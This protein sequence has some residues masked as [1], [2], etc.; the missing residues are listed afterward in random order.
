MGA[1]PSKLTLNCFSRRTEAPR[2]SSAPSASPTSTHQQP[3]K[4]TTLIASKSTLFHKMKL[5]VKGKL[6]PRNA[7][8]DPS[9]TPPPP[10]LPLPT[11]QQLAQPSADDGPV[12]SRTRHAKKNTQ[13]LP[14]SLIP[15]P[16]PPQAPIFAFPPPAGFP[17][18][19]GGPP[20]PPPGFFDQN[21]PHPLFTPEFDF[22]EPFAFSKKTAS[23]VKSK[24]TKVVANLLVRD[25]DDNLSTLRISGRS[26]V[27]SDSEE[28]VLQ[29]FVL[30]ALRE[31]QCPECAAKN[32]PTKSSK[33]KEV[34]SRDAPLFR[35]GLDVMKQARKWIT[36]GKK[37]TLTPI[38]CADCSAHFCLWCS[39]TGVK[40]NHSCKDTAPSTATGAAL[41]VWILLCGLDEIL[42]EEAASTPSPRKQTKSKK[43][44]NLPNPKGTG[45]GGSGSYGSGSWSDDSGFPEEIENGSPGVNPCNKYDETHLQR[46]ITFLGRLIPSIITNNMFPE[47]AKHQHAVIPTMIAKSRLI[48]FAAE[49]L[50][51]DSLQ[52][53]ISLRETFDP[54]LQ[55]LNV[56]AKAPQTSKLCLEEQPIPGKD[57]DLLHISIPPTRWGNKSKGK[58]K[59]SEQEMS[60]PLEGHMQQ[61]LVQCEAFQRT[62]NP[63]NSSK[64]SKTKEFQ[65]MLTLCEG[66]IDLAKLLKVKTEV[67]ETSTS[68]AMSRTT[69]TTAS[70]EESWHRANCFAEIPDDSLV[71]SLNYHFSERAKGIHNPPAGRMKRLLVERVSLATS[72]PPGIFV[73][74]EESRPDV[75]KALILGPA[76]TPYHHGA[77]EFD[78][79]CPH[80]YPSSPPLVQFKTT[81]NG[82]EN[83]NPN[84]YNDGKV[85]LSLL[86]TWSGQP[87]ISGQSTLL[88]VLL[89]LQA[90]V[91]C[92]EPYYNEP[93]WSSNKNDA[94]S[95]AYNQ[96]LYRATTDVGMVEWL[97]GMEKRAKEA[98]KAQKASKA[99]KSG[100]EKDAPGARSADN[101]W[102]GI[103]SHHFSQNAD[104]ILS[105]VKQWNEEVEETV[106]KRNEQQ[107]KKKNNNNFDIPVAQGW[108]KTPL[109]NLVPRLEAGLKNCVRRAEAQ[110]KVTAKAQ[111]PEREQE[112]QSIAI[113]SPAELKTKESEEGENGGVENGRK[114]RRLR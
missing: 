18:L 50:R 80:S 7:N 65:E 37:A 84:L 29:T 93:G 75:L 113:K 68:E 52:E 19:T 54:L 39:A 111:T 64:K 56:L 30:K 78:I 92:A 77:F 17:P 33:A 97:E 90:M 100:D 67:E 40:K 24:V 15:P 47:N 85:C 91:F 81:G 110:A 16:P 94:S 99:K 55:L 60:P 101:V 49:S 57:Q 42:R 12:S 46:V 79:F 83:M 27:D 35:T 32:G 5:K 45:Y 13:A 108:G 63:K 88:Q 22:A 10:P 66:V 61:L 76:D 44:D 4:N 53:V 72:L 109:V 103:L 73:R 82:R 34:N 107:A 74:H 26:P 62:A 89:S 70:K 41:T 59:A 31:Q 48:H 96:N 25:D 102:D 20:I 106:K 112:E 43:Y 51:N 23:K 2:S 58:A 98:E 11:I 36:E 21:V 6:K 3:A 38:E 9:P 87:W 114:R 8:L 104:E 71:N 1:T 28:G 69:S 95:R 14:Q 105:M 86:G